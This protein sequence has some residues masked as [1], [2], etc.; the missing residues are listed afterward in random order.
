M[1]CRDWDWML[2]MAGCT[3]R[4]DPGMWHLV[5]SIQVSQSYCHSPDHP[6]DSLALNTASLTLHKSVQKDKIIPQFRFTYMSNRTVLLKLSFDRH[7]LS[8]LNFS[9]TMLYLEQV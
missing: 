2:S 8:K 5:G 9:K 6:S 4:P 3:F 7:C 1:N